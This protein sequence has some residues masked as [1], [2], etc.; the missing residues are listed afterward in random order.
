VGGGRSTA[1]I[2][3]SAAID[4]AWL[5]G[6]VADVVGAL[7]RDRVHAHD[8]GIGDVDLAVAVVEEVVDHVHR[9]RAGLR[10]EPTVVREHVELGAVG[11]PVERQHRRIV[12]EPDDDD[13]PRRALA[14]EQSRE[15]SRDDRRQE[16]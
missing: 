14:S 10:E 16:G 9:A 8:L 3:H 13:E 11:Q 4:L 1:C 12:F 6:H 15:E 2:E 7:V 5:R